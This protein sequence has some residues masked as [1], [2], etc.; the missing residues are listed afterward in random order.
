MKIFLILI[1]LVSS[2]ISKAEETLLETNISLPV[3]LI[4]NCFYC[5]FGI[6]GLIGHKINEKVI[7][8]GGIQSSY[9]AVQDAKR[10]G[11]EIV[12]RDE[13]RVEGLEFLGGFRYLLDDNK[14]KLYFDLHLGRGE[15]KGEFDWSRKGEGALSENRN[16]Q[17][18][19]LSF[20]FL[21]HFPISPS[22]G[23]NLGALETLV[24][25]DRSSRF[26]SYAD[27]KSLIINIPSFVFGLYLEI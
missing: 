23:L 9:F 5:S 11:N 10:K 4:A 17:F 2:K 20:G 12:G 18:S 13:M 3:T 26:P 7:I 27:R 6:G 15:G 1:L 16:L 8:T 25:Y 22:Y 24:L 21:L 19:T 14:Q